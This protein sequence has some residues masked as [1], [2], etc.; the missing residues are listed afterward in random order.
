VAGKLALEI[1]QSKPFELIEEEAVLNITRTSEVLAQNMAEFLKEFALSA[2][3]YNVLR[4]LRGAGK[5][6]LTCSQLS[7]RLL[8]HDP[9]ITRLLDRMEVRGMVV[10][11]RSKE[12]RR[13][14][15]TCVSQEGLD[16]VNSIDRPLK[17]MLKGSVGK[18]SKSALAALIETLEQV[19][20]VMQ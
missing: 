17:E 7:S 6:G 8:T 11:E 13:L 9:D 19:R 15:I 12:D 3:Q 14:V 5:D 2:T 20:E 1:Q 18:V 4:I 10:R 16:L